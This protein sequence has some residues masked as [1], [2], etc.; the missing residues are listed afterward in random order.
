MKRKQ[1]LSIGLGICSAL[2]LS[3]VSLLYIKPALTVKKIEKLSM[4][5]APTAEYNKFLPTNEE[6]FSWATSL[7]EIGP[8]RPGTEAGQV[9]QDYV[10]S[11]FAE[12]GLSDIEIIPSKTT[13]W[14]CN[15]YS[16][17]INNEHIDSFY[18]AYT[19][20]DGTYGSSS[21]PEN[22]CEGELIYI[23]DS[24]SGEDV[25]GKI[26]L[27]DIPFSTVP[28]IAAK[29]L[30]QLY[31]D[32]N[33]T[34]SLLDSKAIPY[35]TD[36]FYD[37]YYD[38][39]N[40]GAIG[41]I[42][43]LTDYIDSCEYHNEDYSYIGNGNMS[44]PGLWVSNSTGNELKKKLQNSDTVIANITM[45]N[46]LKEV[47]AGAVVGFLPGKSDD[48]IMVQ[49]HYDSITSGATEDASGCS[50]LIGMVKFWSQIPLE[51]RNKTI[52]FIATDTHF[53]DYDTHD[54][55]IEKYFGDNNKIVVNLCIEHIA[56]EM[57]VNSDGSYQLSGEIEPRIIF[58]NGS[59]KLIQIVKEEFVRHKMDRT[60]V[61]PAT[62]LGDELFTDADEFYQEGIPVVNLISGPIYLYDT[63]DTVDK[64]AKE[65]LSP[66]VST[67]SDI[68]MRCMALSDMELKEN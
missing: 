5:N 3:A 48:V 63:I 14:E 59:D 49:S 62:T 19:N 66:T 22:G 11:R 60:I 13:L 29:A 67:M 39:M 16:L 1:L 33:N 54:S 53:S 55:V 44:M 46:T 52:M 47:E 17:Q 27:V 21:T 36:N 30:G 50:C 10:K 8:R 65:A 25:K 68:V 35:V 20:S 7:T 38:C 26:V 41:F 32:P 34:L 42:G 2:I 31:Y 56:S 9:A 28:H 61:L 58:I 51:H 4:Q 37:S 43:I 57:T 18:I 40:N 64:I 15:N 24:Y 6:I 45:Q 12:S 23:G